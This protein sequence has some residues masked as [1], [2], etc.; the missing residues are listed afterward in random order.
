MERKEN[1]L[2]D[3]SFQKLVYFAVIILSII[4]IYVGHKLAVS[5]TDYKLLSNEQ[6]DITSTGYP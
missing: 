5:G 4:F 1:K 6:S 2:S 3:R